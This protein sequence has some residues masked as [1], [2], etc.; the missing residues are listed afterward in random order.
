VSDLKCVQH[1][2]NPFNKNKNGWSYDVWKQGYLL[3][4]KKLPRLEPS[5][6]ECALDDFMDMGYEEGVRQR[7]IYDYTI[8]RL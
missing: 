1:E 5:D 7:S 8:K 6:Q 4:I 3:G 2:L